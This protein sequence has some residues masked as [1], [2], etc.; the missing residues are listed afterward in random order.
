M[1]YATDLLIPPSY[2]SHLRQ[3]LD[4][5]VSSPQ[6]RAL[7]AETD[8]TPQ[9]KRVLYSGVYKAIDLATPVK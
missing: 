8:A 7:T 4:V 6:K 2:A 5:S 9:I 1:E 3:P